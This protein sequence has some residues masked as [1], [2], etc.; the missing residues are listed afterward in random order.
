M[1]RM[2]D[3]TMSRMRGIRNAK[4]MIK[5][6]RDIQTSIDVYVDAIEERY[7][8]KELKSGQEWYRN[9]DALKKAIRNAEFL[10]KIARS[11]LGDA[12][13]LTGN[14]ILSQC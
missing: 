6:L 12:L 2:E 4:A 14:R 10:E 13:R 9:F 5:L 7:G 1:F 3:A 11:S 8:P